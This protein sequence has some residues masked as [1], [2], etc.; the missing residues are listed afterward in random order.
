ME[1]VT[2]VVILQGREAD[3]LAVFCRRS[4][5]KHFLDCSDGG[6]DK[7]EAYAMISAVSAIRCALAEMN[8]P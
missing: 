7:D 2:L 6:T 4:V 1:K 8:I 5:F 3:A